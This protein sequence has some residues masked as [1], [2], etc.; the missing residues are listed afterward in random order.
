MHNPTHLIH[1][2]LAA[3]VVVLFAWVMSGGEGKGRT[4]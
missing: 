4:R 3:L 2:S 1:Y